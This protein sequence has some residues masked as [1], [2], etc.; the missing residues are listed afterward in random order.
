MISHHFP[1]IAKVIKYIYD[2]GGWLVM[3]NMNVFRSQQLTKLYTFEWCSVHTPI[4]MMRYDRLNA[5]SNFIIIY[6]KS[7][8]RFSTEMRMGFL[9][10]IDINRFTGTNKTICCIFPLRPILFL[11]FFFLGMFLLI[12]GAVL[13]A[14]YY[15]L[16][17]KCQ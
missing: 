17:T 10:V 7:C 1:A 16:P 11:V 2:P 12:N 14:Y 3:C 5:R 6:G 13:I 9:C 4:P 15:Y 8:C